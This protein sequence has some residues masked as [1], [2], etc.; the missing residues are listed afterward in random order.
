M[1]VCSH[2]IIRPSARPIRF[3]DAVA[4]QERAMELA[5]AEGRADEMAEYQK[6]LDLYRFGRP[7]RE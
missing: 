5:R 2:T 4:E 7:Y 3:G 1:S 6:H